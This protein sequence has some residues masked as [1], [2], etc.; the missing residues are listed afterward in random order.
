MAPLKIR[1]AEQR[2]LARVGDSAARGAQRDFR[3]QGSR[4][5]EVLWSAMVRGLCYLRGFHG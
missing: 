3:K 5:E 4:K 2:D 1:Q